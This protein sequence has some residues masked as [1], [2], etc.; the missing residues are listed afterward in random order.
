MLCLTK[1]PEGNGSSVETGPYILSALRIAA[2]H[3]SSLILRPFVV[4]QSSWSLLTTMTFEYFPTSINPPMSL[5]PL[6][7]IFLLVAYVAT[8]RLL[9][10]RLVHELDARFSTPDELRN[11]TPFVAQQI[12]QKSVFL[13]LPS[14]ISLGLL[15]SQMKVWGIP[16][17][18]VLLM[19]TSKGVSTTMFGKRLT[20]TAILVATWIANPLTGPGSGA[21]ELYGEG[22]YQEVDVDPR[23]AIA[24]ARVNWLHRKYNIEQAHYL[25]TI[26]L[27]ILEPI[28]FTDE[29][30]WRPL[31]S[32]E[33]H[34]LFV[35]WIE[36]ARR[37]EIEGLWDSMDEMKI[38]KEEY[39]LTHM[40]FSPEGATF[41][42]YGIANF[43]DRFF[44]SKKL[45]AYVFG[46]LLGE[47][48]RKAM[49]LPEP[50]PF[51][52]WCIK[53][54]AR[55][56]GIYT[57][58]FALPRRTPVGWVPTRETLHTYT[59][60]SGSG[61]M[62]RLNAVYKG[63]AGPWYYREPT[64]LLRICEAISLF[65]KR[66]PA[67]QLPGKRWKSQGYRLE[68]LGP[69]RYE[70][71]GHEEVMKIAEEIHGRPITGPW[72]LNAPIQK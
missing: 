5:L 42:Q 34:A 29:Y 55:A 67:S 8:V 41:A 9:R 36:I 31:S 30:G 37:M 6:C 26:A 72:S 68:E 2:P 56:A 14:L 10:Y 54:G 66:Q 21:E 18:S 52:Q 43:S 3:F 19:S 25:Y 17:I 58:F 40:E 12:I 50:S 53:K 7:F 46:T 38:W 20:D 63:E 44:G 32:V 45:T 64:G 27:L 23:S 59:T 71:H 1:G 48:A 28:R 49:S 69:V 57:R 70:K 65:L 61:D 13:E 35:F 47:R 16:S 22:C 51:T 60:L 11:M 62:P 39:E 15:F 24:L 33:K 4:F